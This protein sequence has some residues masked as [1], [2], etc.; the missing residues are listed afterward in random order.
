MN[1][2]STLRRQIDHIFAF[3]RLRKSFKNPY[4][5]ALLRLGVIKLKYFSFAIQHRGRDYVMLARPTTTSAADLFVLREV[6]VEETYQDILALLP[7]HPMRIL[8]VGANIGSFTI[9]LSN[10]MS[11]KEAYCFEPEGDSFRLLRFNLARN[12]CGFAQPIQKAVGGSAR[13]I[14]I[15]LKEDSPGGTTIYS[16]P[17]GK[18]SSSEEVEVVFLHDWLAKVGGSFDLLKIDCEGAEWEILRKCDPADFER[19]SVIVGEVHQDP[20]GIDSVE[21]FGE[22]IE[23][24]GFRTIRWDRKAAGLYV[25]VRDAAGRKP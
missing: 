5:I 11:V 17:G 9:W 18:T 4:L 3:W 21:N 24:L 13:T 10:V 1:L 12:R 23:A 19:F 8:D 15:S 20:E 2:T 14:H 16:N 22:R 25:G 7:K 6:L